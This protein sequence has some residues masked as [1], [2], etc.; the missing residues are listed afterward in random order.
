MPD[1][2]SP[3]VT[4]ESRAY[5]A[6]LERALHAAE[7]S[8]PTV[9]I[10]RQR[11]DQNLSLLKETLATGIEVRVVSKSLPSDGLL[12]HVLERLETNRVMTFNREML[13]SIADTMP[14][15]DQLLGKPLPVAAARSFY[16]GAKNATTAQVA[17]LIDTNERLRQYE[18]L[19]DDL[20]IVVRI[21]LEID[22]GLHR[23]GFSPDDRLEA[24]LRTINS[25]NHL[26]F[27]GFM[28]YEA[29]LAKLPDACGIRARATQRSL[30]VYHNAISMASA[31]F[32]R[33]VVEAATRNSGGSLTYR[34]HPNAVVANEI[35]I[36]T[37]LLKGTDFDTDLLEG[38]LPAVFIAT[39]VLKVLDET[40][41]PGIEFMA[42]TTRRV[43]PSSGKTIFIHGGHWMAKPIHPPGL[44]L[45]RLYGR[46]SNQE[47]LNVDAASTISPD[48]F[49]FLRPTQ[50]EAVLLQFGDIAVYEA[51]EIVE[52]WPVYPASA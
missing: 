34:L 32:S 10:D 27:D 41:I 37:A 21:S 8:Q 24:A 47:M 51:G 28:G 38:F 43:F 45:H 19:A 7:Y 12:R 1:F 46:S 15:V 31:V 17:W 52:T 6:S 13:T 29:H 5:F 16:A 49:V 11:L 3:A 39:P 9:V 22:V 48:S 44:S 33:K 36:G 40:L 4:G 18:A 50:T 26:N 25:S 2:G 30:A 23:G 20:G 42:R 14:T 35:S